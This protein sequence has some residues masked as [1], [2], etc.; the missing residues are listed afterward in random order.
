MADTITTVGAVKYGETLALARQKIL[1]AVVLWAKENEQFA[2]LFEEQTWEQGTDKLVYYAIANPDVAVADVKPLTEGVA[3]ASEDLT[4]AKYE[5]A[6]ENYGTTI[7]YTKEMYQ[8][9]LPEVTQYGATFLST[10]GVQVLDILKAKALAASKATLTFPASGTTKVYDAFQSAYAQLTENG[11]LPWNGSNYIAIVTGTVAEQLLKEAKDIITHTSEKEAVIKGYIGSIAGFDIKRVKSKVLSDGTN[12]T[13]IFM[14]RDP[15]TG[16][17][18]AV[19]YSLHGLDVTIEPLGS[20][21]IIDANG[22]YRKDTL[23]Q[24]GSIGITMDCFAAAVTNDKC[25]LTCKA[26]DTNFTVVKESAIDL[27]A[28]SNFVSGSKKTSPSATTGKDVTPGE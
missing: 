26:A 9:G 21:T 23:K 16:S 3:P 24:L 25:V 19:T 12:Q 1:D 28:R 10:W 5:I 15:Y 22:N 18:P 14:G 27:D 13:I 6:C 7:N 8:K 20:G 17:K 2:D 4:F 11:A